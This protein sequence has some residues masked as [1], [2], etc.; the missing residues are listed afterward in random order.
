VENKQ[1][2][3]LL[4]CQSVIQMNNSRVRVKQQTWMHTLIRK[5]FYFSFFI[6]MHLPLAA[7]MD[8]R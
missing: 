4:T 6:P 7:V 3:P 5:P 2:Q 8:R 1:E